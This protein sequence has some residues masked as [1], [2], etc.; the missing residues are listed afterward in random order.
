MKF[1][2]SFAAY[3]SPLRPWERRRPRRQVFLPGP[4]TSRRLRGAISRK[5]RDDHKGFLT[6]NEHEW[7]QMIIFGFYG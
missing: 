2:C 7:T 4:P 3:N 1:P 6:T 5:G